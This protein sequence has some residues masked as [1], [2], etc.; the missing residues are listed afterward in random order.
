MASGWAAPLLQGPLQD[1]RPGCLKVWVADG[2]DLGGFKLVRLLHHV[3]RAAPKQW[4]PQGGEPG[5][6]QAWV[7]GPCGVSDLSAAPMQGGQLPKEPWPSIKMCRG[8]AETKGRRRCPLLPPMTMGAAGAH[9]PF[10]QGPYLPSCK[11]RANQCLHH[12]LLP[13]PGD[14]ARADLSCPCSCS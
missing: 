1:C 9:S 14:E 4:D 10:I 13:L 5:C 12:L 6:L 8:S 3:A 2:F 11:H 7:A